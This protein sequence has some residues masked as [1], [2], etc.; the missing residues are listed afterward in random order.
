M[1][2]KVKILETAAAAAMFQELGL[3]DVAQALLAGDYVSAL[4][5]FYNNLAGVFMSHGLHGIIKVIMKYGAIKY[6]VNAL[7]GTGKTFSF[8]GLIDLEV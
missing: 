1:A 4:N 2:L 6:V 8:L 7:P 3:M 5:S